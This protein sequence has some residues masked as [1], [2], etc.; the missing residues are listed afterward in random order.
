MTDLDCDWEKWLVYVICVW[1]ILGLN[2]EV[3]G[4]RYME[5]EVAV[6][7][8]HAANGSPYSA[9][10]L[11]KILC[12][13]TVAGEWYWACR[14]GTQGNAS[15]ME[16]TGE[17]MPAEVFV[18]EHYTMMNIHLRLCMLMCIGYFLSI[19][20]VW[21]RQQLREV[22]TLFPENPVILVKYATSVVVYYYALIMTRFSQST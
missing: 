13:E 20:S 6:N 12:E 8:K 21:G 3:L 16:R 7:E 15:N 2:T 5:I 14:H 9:E 10:Q 1:T 22:G 19:F 18:W 17:R 4:W 11:S